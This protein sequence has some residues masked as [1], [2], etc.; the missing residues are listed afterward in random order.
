MCSSLMIPG[1]LRELVAFI[2]L[3]DV[4]SEMFFPGSHPVWLMAISVC[5]SAS[6][7]VKRA[8]SLLHAGH[9]YTQEV[10]SLHRTLRTGVAVS[11]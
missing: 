2:P 4:V 5:S 11:M 6:L 9:L 3:A 1:P 7:Q 10:Q 8:P